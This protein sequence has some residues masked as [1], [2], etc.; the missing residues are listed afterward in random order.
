M[1]GTISDSARIAVYSASAGAGKTFRL[2]VEYG[3]AALSQ[4]DDPKVF[5]RILGLTFTNKAAHEMK[6]RVLRTLQNV[7]QDADALKDPIAKEMA[8][9]LDV[10]GEELRRRAAAVLSEMLHDYGSVSLGTLDQFTH[11]LVRTFAI[12]LGL[13]SQFEVELDD[14]YLLDLAV[15][16]LMADLGTDSALTSLVLDFARANLEDDRQGDVF[17]AL[18]SM[19]KHLSKEASNQAVAALREWDLQRHQTLQLSLRAK[20]LDLRKQ[21]RSA[22]PKLIKLLA[23]LPAE[24]VNRP[25]YYASY[26]KKLR[27]ADAKL[28]VP[29]THVSKSLMGDPVAIL[30]VAGQKDSALRA[31]AE[32]V[33]GRM[34]ALLG[35]PLETALDGVVLDMLRRHDRSASVLSE[36][37]RRLE[38]V[39]DRL[40]VQPIWKFQPL[41]HHELRNQPA[42]YLFERLGER[43]SRFLVDEAQD[44]S[45]MQWA[46]LWPLMEHAL[47]GREAGAGAMLVGDGKQS[48][49]RW[50]GSDAEEFLDLVARAKLGQSPSD[51]FPGLEGM[52][53]FVPLADNWRSRHEI[54]EF[55]N[56]LFTSLAGRMGQEDH[57][58]AYAEAAQTPKGAEGGF[59]QLRALTGEDREELDALVLDALVA[60]VKNRHAAGWDWGSMAVLMRRRAEGRMVAERFAA[61]GIPILSSELLAVTGSASVQLMAALFRWM[62]RPGE[63]ERE[64]EVLRGLRRAGVWKVGVQEWLETGQSRRVVSGIPR[65]EPFENVLKRLIP[66]WHPAV[67]WRLSLYEMG[68]YTS[69]VLG[70]NADADAFV[71]RMLDAMLDFSKR[72]VNRLEAF[73]EEFE[74]RADTWSVSAPAGADAVELLTIH[75]AKGL[76]FPL[77]FVPWAQL[78]NPRLDPVWLDPRG[79]LGKGIDLPP[80]SLVSLS[81][82]SSYDGLLD[83]VAQ[84]WPAYGASVQQ[85]VERASFDDA[86]LL[87]VATTRAVDEL[88]V[89]FDPKK[90]YGGWWKDYADSELQS[91][92]ARQPGEGLWAWGSSPVPGERGLPAASWNQSIV[93]NRDWTSTV[94]LAR[95]RDEEPEQRFGNALHAALERIRD[96]RD[97]STAAYAAAER[98]QLD[99][100]ERDRLVETLARAIK[101]PEL[102]EWWSAQETY[103]ERSL[104]HEGGVLRPDRIYRRADGRW[105]V[106]DYKTGAPKPE[107][108]AQVRQYAD[109][110]E[111]V[112]GERPLPVLLYLRETEILVHEFP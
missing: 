15:F 34:K 7:V 46:N 36:L 39:L 50:R 94:R 100:A 59:V 67:A 57:R 107:H 47:T 10:D 5:R 73:M 112:L 86:N 56:R 101:G 14:D 51:E 17:D 31:Q 44:T 70:F 33:V 83:A 8:R 72:Q 104:L 18:K 45:R 54:V 84:R 64:W 26:F 69:R 106:A 58:S 21:M 109:L 75:K 9:L 20:A 74:R 4:P 25:D 6:E 19:A 96:P 78:D 52:S 76:E 102:Q 95:A 13:P 48:I 29:G 79:V 97:A 12:E 87:Y 41:I 2:A 42:S 60:D 93:R 11:R 23:E 99:A 81:K 111:P 92:Q 62:L 103:T 80:S 108:E 77:V 66:N 49:Y 43:Y 105:V 35:D 61:E 68:A 63:P 37:A 110:L 89:Y 98:H 55:N 38:D 71:M 88:W 53:G 91:G 28:W 24:S 82:F 30:K 1:A 85:A 65:P 3:S 22:S 32:D 40:R 90:G 16:E 27:K